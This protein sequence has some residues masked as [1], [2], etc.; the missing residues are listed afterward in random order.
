MSGAVLGLGSDVEDYDLPLLDA[1]VQFGRRKHF[2][3]VPLAQV[4]ARQR[5]VTSATW[6]VATSRTAA[7]NSAT[8]SLARR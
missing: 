2:D 8:R 4:F 6:R 3:G 5:T 7:H 1:L